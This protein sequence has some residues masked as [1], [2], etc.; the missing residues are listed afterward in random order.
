MKPKA[1]YSKEVQEHLDG[2]FDDVEFI[3]RSLSYQTLIHPRNEELKEEAIKCAVNRMK[4]LILQRDRFI[5]L[6]GDIHRER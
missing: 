4:H 3:L 5:E 1:K 6:I 2:Y